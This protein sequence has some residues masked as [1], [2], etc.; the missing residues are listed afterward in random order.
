MKIFQL[1]HFQNKVNLILLI[2]GGAVILGGLLVLVAPVQAAPPA[3]APTQKPSVM[4]GQSLWNENCMPCHGPSGLGNGP[5]AQDLPSPPPN[6]TD[7]EIARNHVPAD[8]FNT[9]KNGRMDKMMPPW[10]DKLND[11]EIW[12]AVSYVWRLGTSSQE[13]DAGEQIFADQCAACHGEGGAGDGPQ[14]SAAINDFTNLDAMAQVSQADLFAAYNTVD[15]HT[16]ITDVS[17][18]DL[19]AALDYVRSFSFALPVRNG[20]LTGQVI[21]AATGQPVGNIE[22]TLHAFQNGT[23]IDT[24]TGQ[25]DENGNFTFYKL[26]TD[27]TIFYVVQGIYQDVVYVSQDPG[28]FLPDSNQVNLNLEVYDTTTNPENIAV[29]QL[30]YLVSFNPGVVNVLQ[31]YIVGNSGN[32]TFI[33]EDGKTFAFAL[34][35]NAADV[36]FQNDSEGRFI[37]TDSGYVDTEPVVPG[38]EGL[39][40]AAIYNIPFDSDELNIEFPLPADVKSMDVMMTEQGATLTSDQ[41]DFSDSRD[42][43]G[44]SFSVFSRKNLTKGETISLKLSGLN[45]LE[46]APAAPNGSMA[47]ASV[48][49]DTAWFNQN[50]ARWV[51]LGLGLIAVVVAVVVYPTRRPQL[52]TPTTDSPETRRQKLLLTLA[53]L[54][55]VYEN[56][57]LDEEVYTRARAKYKAELADLMEPPA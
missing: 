21:N 17:E 45:N 48:P 32:K 52:A 39:T 2:S 44:T 20:A 22:V 1:R 25:A 15:Q 50:Y 6:F 3:Q 11:Q 5:T 13:L 35:K 27:H 29:T 10:K 23:Q 38:E 47:G 19:W 36:S 42:F 55:E 18:T 37:Q 4:G 34:P 8:V 54:D 33:G 16:D 57:E 26:L 7:P 28:M 31:I 40:I 46:F 14:A 53:R 9:I 30:H 12:N 51:V 41:V 43:Q 56:G 49:A 24:M